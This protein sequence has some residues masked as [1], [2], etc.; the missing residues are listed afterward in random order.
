MSRLNTE[1]EVRVRVVDMV[2]WEERYLMGKDN[3]EGEV[4][5]EGKNRVLQTPP[6]GEGARC[7]G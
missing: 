3:R 4:V 6:G 7:T 5:M 1:R 2:R